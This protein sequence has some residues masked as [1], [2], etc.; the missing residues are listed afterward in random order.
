LYVSE[1]RQEFIASAIGTWSFS[2]HD[3]TDDE[4]VFA[5]L[6]MVKHALQMEELQ[7]WRMP[8][9]KVPAVSLGLWC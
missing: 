7:Q 9:G 5:A 8:D 1:D 2:A 3:F 4:L 6:L